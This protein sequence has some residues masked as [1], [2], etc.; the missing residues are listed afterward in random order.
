MASCSCFGSKFRG[1]RKGSSIKKKYHSDNIPFETIQF[2]D[3]ADCTIATSCLSPLV[4]TISNGLMIK[5]N[6]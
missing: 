4:S 6:A 3:C 5:K 2:W 1:P